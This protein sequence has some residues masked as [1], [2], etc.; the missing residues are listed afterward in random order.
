MAAVHPGFDLR[1]S[2]SR[3]RWRGWMIL[4]LD[5]AAAAD[6]G[7]H[8][9]RRCP[10]TIAKALAL[11]A[12][13]RPAH[14]A[15]LRHPGPA[16]FVSLY[17]R[18]HFDS[19]DGGAEILHPSLVHPSSRSGNFFYSISGPL[20]S[21]RNG[22]A[23]RM[24]TFDGWPVREAAP[25][26]VVI[27]LGSSPTHLLS[28]RSSSAFGR[29]GA[30]TCASRWAIISTTLRKIIQLGSWIESK[31]GPGNV[32][33]AWVAKRAPRTLI[34]QGDRRALAVIGAG[35]RE[36]ERKRSPMPSLE[37]EPARDR[38][39]RVALTGL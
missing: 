7:E 25:P 1:S 22:R 8:C 12:P 19:F 37:V 26:T 36:E 39:G 28:P 38:V 13:G 4:S 29:T 34:K 2:F 21:W 30:S 35:M 17:G 9:T 33:T 11:L 24:N 20:Q 10:R 32:D 31:V 27:P 3:S 18:D 5:A 23:T 14:S 16:D 15:K 6:V